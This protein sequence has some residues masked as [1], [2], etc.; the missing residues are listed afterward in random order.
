MECR[1]IEAT[2]SHGLL[3]LPDEVVLQ[4]DGLAVGAEPHLVL[5][6]ELLDG[7]LSRGTRAAYHSPTVTTVMLKGA[8]NMKKGGSN[9]WGAH[10]K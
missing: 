5:H 7:E 8:H 4:D 6:L 9:L 10:E 3:G 1:H 2:M